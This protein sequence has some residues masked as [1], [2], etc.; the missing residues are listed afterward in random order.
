M[1]SK[2]TR[3]QKEHPRWFDKSQRNLSSLGIKAFDRFVSRGLSDSEIAR[4]MQITTAGARW[5]RTKIVE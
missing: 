5:R 2:A 3:K 1:A 4:K